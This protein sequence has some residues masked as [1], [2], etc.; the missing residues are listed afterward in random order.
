SD[1]TNATTSGD[2]NITVS[3]A[4]T[5]FVGL[6]A[7]Y[8][9]DEGTGASVTDVSS[10]GNN[11]TISGASWTNSGRYGRA[12]VFNGAG[13]LVRISDAASLRLTNGMTLEAWVNP[14]AV[15]SAWRDVIYK[16]NDNYYLSA[17]SSNNKAPVGGAIVSGQYAEAVGTAGLAVNTWSHLAATFDGTAMRLYV[18]GV[19]V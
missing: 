19:L 14:S 13:A 18:N 11:G 3:I 8:G 7:A 15:S 4:P 1:G 10:N 5:N 9:F 12:L 17:T 6:V 2:L 16:G